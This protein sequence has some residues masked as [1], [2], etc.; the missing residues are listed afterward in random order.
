MARPLATPG[1][2]FGGAAGR[3]A[4]WLGLGGSLPGLGTLAATFAAG[5]VGARTAPWI[6][7]PAS[8]L[9]GI[10]LVAARR[11]ALRRRCEAALQRL[12]AAE[13]LGPV[14][15]SDPF[16]PLLVHV[17]TLRSREAALRDTLA[18]MLQNMEQSATEITN[19]AAALAGTSMVQAVSVEESRTTI[20]Q[21]VLQIDDEKRH[22]ESAT[23]VSSRSGKS[24][25]GVQ[26]DMHELAEA[27]QGIRD[28]SQE[29]ANILKVVDEIAFQTNLL[30][31]NAAIEAARAGEA[32]RGFGVVAE[33]VR[34]LAGRSTQSARTIAE[35]VRR[36][37][38]R[39]EQGNSILQRTGT[40]LQRLISGTVELGGALTQIADGAQRQR[41]CIEL[42]NQAVIQ[43]DAASQ[44]NAVS[45]E[46]LGAAN[47]KLHQQLG[48]LRATVS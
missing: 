25:S 32:G 45:G 3:V 31:L 21:I 8:L 29:I 5:S 43:L 17:D 4:R 26:S 22:L 47:D 23:E 10:A 34:A 2:R 19:A 36:A 44:T 41:E 30:A 9:L 42:V 15:R 11:R 33:E 16:A 24:V 7:I 1:H 13:P 12:N 37:L 40:S 38:E 35:K 27:M 6:W 48:R 46:E 18:A 39:V 20:D 14:V 28:S